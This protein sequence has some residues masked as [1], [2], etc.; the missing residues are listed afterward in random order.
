M[1]EVNNQPAHGMFCVAFFLCTT[2]V[3]V[4]NWA[5]TVYDLLLHH[6]SKFFIQFI[7]FGDFAITKESNDLLMNHISRVSGLSGI[8]TIRLRHQIHKSFSVGRCRVTIHKYRYLSNLHTLYWSRKKVD[9]V[10]FD[11]VDQSEQVRI[12][13]WWWKPEIF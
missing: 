4:P 6:F 11:F 8:N 2:I 12:K 10:Q 5:P 1:T 13:R 7:V 9:L 3:N